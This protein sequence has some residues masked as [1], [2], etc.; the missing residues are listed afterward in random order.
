MGDFITPGTEEKNGY[1]L[2]SKLGK[3]DE[4]TQND[5]VTLEMAKILKPK[6]ILDQV[7]VSRQPKKG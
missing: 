1:A 4:I 7:H 3:V 6:D 2:T 5:R